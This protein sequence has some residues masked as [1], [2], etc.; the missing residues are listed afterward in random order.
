MRV[1]LTTYCHLSRCEMV[2]GSQLIIVRPADDAKVL[3]AVLTDAGWTVSNEV[4]CQ[5]W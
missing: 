2:T 4:G 5:C 1:A 3:L